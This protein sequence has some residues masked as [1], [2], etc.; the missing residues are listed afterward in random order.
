VFLMH[1]SRLR[2]SFAAFPLVVHEL[3]LQD[4]RMRPV[5]LTWFSGIMRARRGS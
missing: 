2:G 5:P 3:L 4:G 1:L